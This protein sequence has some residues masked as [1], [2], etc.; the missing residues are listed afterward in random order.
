M[1]EPL[2]P[3]KNHHRLSPPRVPDVPHLYRGYYEN[4]HG[5]QI[6]YVHDRRTGEAVLYHGDLGWAARPVIEGVAQDLIL[7]ADEAAWVAACWNAAVFTQP[8]WQRR[9]ESER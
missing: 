6:L 9:Q 4:Q 2:L 1:D 7:N 8:E 3:L 5:E